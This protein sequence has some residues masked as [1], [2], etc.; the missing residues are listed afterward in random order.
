MSYAVRQDGGWR[1]V[2]TKDDL[3]DGE[4]W[5]EVQPP[6]PPQPDPRISEIDSLLADI[7][8]KGARPSREI[9][10]ALAAGSPAPTGSVQKLAELEAQA[11]T[12][13]AERRTLTP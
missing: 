13:R 5:S 3:L 11:E 6:L 8:L 9:A 12:L 4:T 2:N 10:A 7:D 1:A